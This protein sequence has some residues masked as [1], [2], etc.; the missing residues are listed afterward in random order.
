MFATCIHCN[1][2]LG[3]NDAIE[4]FPVGRRLAFDA[5]RGR[6]WVICP[7]CDRW[8]LSPLD[9]RWDAIEECERRF[10]AT[11]VR[12]STEQIGLAR[13]PEGVDLIRIGEPQR[14]EFAA[15]RY[16]DQFGRR[17]KR[18]LLI[19]G[20]ALTAAGAVYAGGVW[21]GGIGVIGWGSGLLDTVIN[22]RAGATVARVRDAKGEVRR[23]S[24]M[25]AKY[26]V[27]E[28]SAEGAPLAVR[29]TH[30]RGELRLEG[31]GAEQVI[32]QLLPSVNRFG[33]TPQ[34][35]QR[36]VESLE[37]LGG[38]HGL[39]T[40]LPALHGTRADVKAPIG[41]RVNWKGIDIEPP[42]GTLGAINPAHR[43][44]L[45]MALHEEQERRALE[46]EL[47]A[48]AAAWR[49]AEEIAAIA[50]GMFVAAPVEARLHELK[51]VATRTDARGEA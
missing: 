3:R 10:S 48:L 16:G 29:V 31:P 26:A 51:R 19:T 15:W 13:L 33:G 37:V 9:E 50:D 11:R 47:D 12:T 17:R 2:A 27:I 22:G 25:H 41:W 5:R 43:L 46:G 39:L 36:A 38:S 21:L 40:R 44:A 30:E 7:A 34:Q 18:Q 8:N 24:R 45:E 4:V 28:R 20:A 6:L 23:I 32:R 14:P 35:V 1:G 49:D 42:R